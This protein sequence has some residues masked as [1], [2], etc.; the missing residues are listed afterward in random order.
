MPAAAGDVSQR[1]Q[2]RAPMLWMLA[3]D[4]DLSRFR[5]I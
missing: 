4:P 3:P 5:T 1:A 2:T